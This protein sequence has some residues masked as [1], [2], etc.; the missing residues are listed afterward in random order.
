M[1][2]LDGV[3]IG[4]GDFGVAGAGM[5]IGADFWKVV[6]VFVDRIYYN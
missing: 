1:E 2:R 5:G 3:D 6:W 4:R